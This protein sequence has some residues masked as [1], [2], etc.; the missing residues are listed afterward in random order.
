M[1]EGM[2]SPPHASAISSAEEVRKLRDELDA[3]GKK[4]VFTNG[5]FDL[6]HA[7][8][9]RYLAEA[10]ALGDALVVALNSDASV[11]ELK[12][13]SRPVNTEED[14]G[15]ILKALRSVDA[16]CVFTEPRVTKLI[17]QIKP[18]VYAKG[19]DYT[20]ASL[21]PEER[22]ALYSVGA[23]IK[24]LALVPGRSTTKTLQ[25]IAC[26]PESSTAPKKLRIGVLGSGTGSNFD[27]IRT[28]IDDG[29]LLAEIVC[30][31]SDHNKSG[32]ITSARKAGLPAFFV[33][34]GSNPRRFP[35]SAQK[36]VCEHLQRANVDVVV[37][38]GFMRIVRDPVLTE[39]KDR[40]INLH[41]SLL[42]K[43]KG[44]DAVQR[45]IDDGELETG[46]TIHIVTAHVDDGRILAQ[47]TVP[48]EIGDTAEI[49]H[50]R[51]KKEEHKL[52]PKVLSDWNKPA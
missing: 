8:H 5:C 41:P 18:H 2:E 32:I 39:F 10:R 46:T 37:L 7:G 6:L 33:D 20:I 50:E 21:N 1:N 43:F 25:R 28:A 9:V 4:L 13:P 31:I 51:I 36:E 35:D 49:V 45:A 23:E 22:A 16:V 14:R 34:P 29:S 47:A 42:P 19:G 40:I 15:E 48:I 24:I 52:L 12:G 44:S 38:A 3:A 30:V 11:R 17:E 27:A 26:E